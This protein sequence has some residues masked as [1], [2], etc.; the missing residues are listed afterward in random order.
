VWGLAFEL[1]PEGAG[2]VALDD[3]DGVA[4]AVSGGGAAG[5]VVDRD[6]VRFEAAGRD[7]VER[8]VQ[9]SVAA[10]VEPVPV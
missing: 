9:L 5:G 1:S 7:R 10:T 2:E 3:A 8:S 6:R 4:A